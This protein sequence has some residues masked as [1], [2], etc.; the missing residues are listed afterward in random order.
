MFLPDLL[1][2][3]F[4]GFDKKQLALGN[5]WRAIPLPDDKSLHP[6]GDIFTDGKN[7]IKATFTRPWE[8]NHLHGAH[9]QTLPPCAFESCF[10]LN[11]F[12]VCHEFVLCINPH[13]H[14]MD[15][16]PSAEDQMHWAYVH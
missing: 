11:D 13:S 15:D 8:F 10:P 14:T 7:M 1:E 2:E 4:H 16:G 3:T 6:F 12:G 5:R 9:K